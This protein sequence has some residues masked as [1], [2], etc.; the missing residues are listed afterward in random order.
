MPSTTWSAFG[1]DPLFGEN[2]VPKNLRSPLWKTW[3][4]KSHINLGASHIWICTASVGFMSP[5][6][7]KLLGAP[8]SNVTFL[9]KTLSFRALVEAPSSIKRGCSGCLDSRY[10]WIHDKSL[11]TWLEGWVNSRQEFKNMAWRMLCL[12]AGMGEFTTRV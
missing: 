2:M 12:I 11:R 3:G 1:S 4:F 5:F 10:G 7:G 8:S 6:W 9:G